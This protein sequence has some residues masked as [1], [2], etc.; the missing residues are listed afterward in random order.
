MS[1]EE[2]SAGND[3]VPAIG[4]GKRLLFWAVG[5]VLAGGFYLL[6]IDT[7]NAPELYAGAFATLTA[8]I[9][10]EAAREQGFAEIAVVGRWLMR[11]PRA[12]AR[13]PQDVGVLAA[14][15]VSQALRPRP[16][17]GTLRAIPFEHGK[18]EGRRDAGRRALAE[19]AGSVSPN[20]IIVGIDEDSDLMLAHQLRRSGGAR[21]IDV[22]E[23]G[24]RE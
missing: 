12:F 6:L 3:R 4:W 14:S 9:G 15:A 17:R 23:L 21:A 19:A 7:V 2:E 10:F 8:A 1:A 18:R 11:T 5:C 22:L 24:E 20:T 16:R 13:I